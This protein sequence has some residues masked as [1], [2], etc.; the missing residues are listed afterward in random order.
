MRKQVK[1]ITLGIIFCTFGFGIIP[2]I[3]VAWIPPIADSSI[4]INYEILDYW[5]G[6]ASGTVISGDKTDTYTNNGIFLK[7]KSAHPGFPNSL[8]I[9]PYQHICKIRFYFSQRKYTKLIFDWK[10]TGTID[11][12]FNIAFIGFYYTDGFDPWGNRNLKEGYREYSVDSSR[13]LVCVD[14]IYKTIYDYS[15]VYQSFDYIKVFV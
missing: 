1:Y 12:I 7:I 3:A 8:L 4:V 15:A 13:T 14:F 2:T 6:L 5:P 10:V 11:Q 9:S